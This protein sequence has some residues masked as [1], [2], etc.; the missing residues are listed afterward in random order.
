M[1]ETPDV[2]RLSVGVW[3]IGLVLVAIALATALVAVVPAGQPYDEPAHHANVVFYAEERRMPVLGEPDVYYEGQMGPGYYLPAAV[4]LEAT[5]TTH[6][7]HEG[8]RTLRY[9]GLV[10]IPLAG[11]LTFRLARR[12]GVD[13]VRSG[14]AA[15]LV[16]LNPT[17]LAIGS[18]VQNDY[19][20]I[21]VA[22]VGAALA[23]LAL[24]PKASWWQS[25]AAG[26]VIGLAIL[27]K[28][29][30]GGL[31]VG[32]VV[33]SLTDR[34]QPWRARLA[35]AGSATLAASAVSGW[36]FARNLA[37]YGD[38][39]GAKGV[40]RTGASFPPLQLEGVSSVLGWVRSLISYGFA[41]TEYYR[42]AFDAPTAVKVIAVLVTLAVATLVGVTLV[43]ADRSTW[44]RLCGDPR[45]VF[46]A[47]TV[48]VVALAYATAAW[49]MQ[50]IAPRLMFVAA[51]LGVVLLA[52][53]S[54]GRPGVLM[55]WSIV[56]SFVVIDLWLVIVLSGLEAVPGVFPWQ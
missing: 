24:A 43:R 47:T 8:L 35:R 6:A 33:A 36:W 23:L 2:A 31:L 40:E 53:L 51:P 14:L 29:F 54:T 17:M 12:T 28:V 52:R 55:L 41:P 7:P 13:E 27:V 16:A 42:N 15:G 30:A 19:L 49:S 11:W 21:V 32:L 46:A 5:G 20:N 1:W 45:L 26:A 4:V 25:A 9:L 50:A 10:L 3:A 18:S 56:V 34:S 37:L 38:L 22:A 39:T 44:V 48:G